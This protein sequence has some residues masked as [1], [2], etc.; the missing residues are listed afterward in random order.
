[1]VGKTKD[2]EFVENT[3]KFK[4]INP[5]PLPVEVSFAMKKDAAQNTFSIS[6]P[7]L[8]L[9]PEESS[10]L[11]IS[12]FPR[13]TGNFGDSVI[14]CVKDNPYP[15]IFDVEAQGV[16]PEIQVDRKSL[17]FE[18]VLLHRLTRQTL[19]LLNASDL[20]ISWRIEGLEN[21]G[22]EFVP[23][24]DSGIIKAR[25][26]FEFHLD[27]RALKAINIKRK[28]RVVVGDLDNIIGDCQTEIIEVLAEAYD[29]ALDMRNGLQL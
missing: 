4:I 2:A 22:D 28:I 23:N 20:A 10:Y 17:N 29:V 19:K 27:F 18:K 1:M 25:E 5:G 15:L 3:L 8:N 24:Q 12:A 21:L 16:K 6:P 14:C 26:T 13:T 9:A 7:A 11:V